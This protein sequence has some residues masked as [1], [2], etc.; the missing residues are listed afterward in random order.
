[1]KDRLKLLLEN[2]FIY[3]VINALDKIVPI[4]M[5]PIITR[6]LKDTEEFGK[7]DMF[8]TVISFG[9][10]IAILGMYDA[11][12]REYFEKDDGDYKLKV[13]SSS[14]ITVFI[15]SLAVTFILLIFR[16]GFSNLFIGD[17]SGIFIVSTAAI[18][19]FLSANRSIICAPTRMK[20]QR[21]VFVFS[22]FLYTV[23]HYLIAVILIFNGFGYEAMIYSNLIALFLCIVFFMIINKK[24]F[25]PNFFDKKLAK[26]LLKIGIPLLPTFL[27]YWVFNSID[28]IMIIRTMGFGQVGIYSIGAKVAS[29]SNFIYA[30]FAG[31]WQYFAFSIMGDDDQVAVNSKIYEYLGIFSFT[32]FYLAIIFGKFVFQIVFDEEYVL[33][34]VVFPLLFI[35]PLL[36]MLFQI[37]GNQFLV[38]KKTYLLTFSL[39]VGVILNISF[40]FLLIKSFGIKGVSFSTF[41]GY[42][43]SVMI[44][45]LLALKYELI[46]INK[47]LVFSFALVVLNAVFYLLEIYLLSA[48]FLPTVSILI[49]ILL[50]VKDFKLG[51]QKIISTGKM[52]E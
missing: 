32:L 15:S 49:T 40:N 8:H 31:G 46:C 12:F 42:A 41:T 39:I 18:G 30:A 16:N 7:L 44:A 1:M 10:S 26:E 45:T 37:V 24:H 11:M 25:K 35:S 38:I 51:I 36:L 17:S 3:G 29:V 50:Y 52:G 20:N 6:L 4:I 34:H 48:Y 22:G 13:T 33:G 28:R 2:F 43:V 14:A 21:K 19:V 5:L 9:S 23:P 47:K 27:I